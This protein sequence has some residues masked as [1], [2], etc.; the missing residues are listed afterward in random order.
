MSTEQLIR[1]KEENMISGFSKERGIFSLLAGPLSFP[2]SLSFY[3]LENPN[4][5][6]YKIVIS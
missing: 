4:L 6:F 2:F 3:I 1:N 5:F